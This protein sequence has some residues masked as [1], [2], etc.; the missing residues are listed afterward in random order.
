MT[1][2]YVGGGGARIPREAPT[3]EGTAHD[4]AC[5][6]PHLNGLR[7]EKGDVDPTGMIP[8]CLAL[9]HYHELRELFQV[10]SDYYLTIKAS[11]MKLFATRIKF[12]GH[13]L[14][15]G[16]RRA[17]PEMIAAIERWSPEMIKTPT[18]MHPGI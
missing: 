15:Y 10:F 2:L 11:T 16:E 1:V 9:K 12:V 18:H 7:D 4:G 14:S 5:P 8:D 13:I 3:H 6:S 17:D